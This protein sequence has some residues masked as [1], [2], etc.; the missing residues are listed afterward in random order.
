MERK[1]TV[2]QE[3]AQKQKS[4]VVDDQT[5]NNNI[6]SSISSPLM[7][8]DMLGFGDQKSSVGF[9]ELLGLQDFNNTCSNSS[10]FDLLTAEELVVGRSPVQNQTQ[11]N[12]YQESSEVLNNPPTPNS[13]SL[14]SVSSGEEK[15]KVVADEQEQQQQHK[16]TKPQLK[17]KK[18]GSQ[19]KKK[20]TEPRFAFMTKSE[21]DHLE[22][23]YRWRKYGQKAV[24]NSPFPRSYYR[25]TS[26]SCNVKK[27]VERSFNDPSIVVTTYEGQHTHQSPVMPR[28]IHAGVSSVSGIS[29]LNFPAN[30]HMN[31]LMMQQQQNSNNFALPSNCSQ[32][33]MM[34]NYPNGY[35]IAD[36]GGLGFGPSSAMAFLRDNGLLQDVVPSM[37]RTEDQ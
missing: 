34:N 27:R 14:S 35:T 29:P 7:L 30:I 28:G 25:C 24:K 33:T 23:G 36:G 10:I 22:D 9:M 15:T 11:L 16:V 2:K 3:E 20:Q 17:G 13:S 32:N 31:N 26:T 18:S 21:V 8:S 4:F 37:I 6:S 5:D 1:Q 19:K 12:P